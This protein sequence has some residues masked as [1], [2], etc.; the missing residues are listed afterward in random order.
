M[1]RDSSGRIIRYA[2]KYLSSNR[3]LLDTFKGSDGHDIGYR[4]GVKETLEVK[5]FKKQAVSLFKG[6]LRK[7]I[8]FL[9]PIK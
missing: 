7:I 8:P 5:K 1:L 9:K 4:V 6:K 2:E 3:E